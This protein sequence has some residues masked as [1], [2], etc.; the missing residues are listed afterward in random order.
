VGSEMGVRACAK[1]C[2]IVVSSNGGRWFLEASAGT[3][4]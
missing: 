1:D 3:I 4:V 2:F